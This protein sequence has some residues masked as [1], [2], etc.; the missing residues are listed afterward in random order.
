MLRG[1]RWQFLA[2]ILATIL[3]VISLLSRT[4]SDSAGDVIPS[5]EPTIQTPPSPVV[6]S[7]PTPLISQPQPTQ[8]S[9]LFGDGI[10]TYRE[11][12]V[13]NV[14]RLNPL[15]AGLNPVDQDITA[16]IFEGLIRINQ[17][18]E[19]EPALAREWVISFDGL[20]YVFILR[21]DILWQ[22][23]VP[24]TADDV[25]FTMSLLSAPDFPGPESLRAFWRTVEVEKLGEHMVRFR[26]AQRLGS[27]LDALRIGILPYH[28]L[29]GTPASALTGHRFNL[30]PVG[31]GPY[32][33]EAIRAEGDRIRAVDLRVSPVY[34]VRPGVESPL[35]LERIS[36]RLFDT[37]NQVTQALE[38]GEVDGYAARSRV[39][40]LPLLAVRGDFASH[41]TI[42]PALGVIIFNWTNDDLPYFRDMRVR[43]ALQTGL[44]RTSIIERHLLN[45]AV[46]ADSPLLQNS[47]AYA[48]GLPW[49]A[50]SIDVARSLLDRANVRLVVPEGEDASQRPA[51]RFSFTILTVS[52]PALVNV[53]QE[54]ATQWDQ[55]NINAEVE[56]VDQT[57]FFERLQSGDFGAA[58]VELSMSG[59]ADPD[60]YA[61]WHQGQYPDGLNYGGANDRPTSEQLE[62]ARADADGT[63]RIQ[64]YRLFQ[65]EFIERAVAIPLYYPL[66]TYVVTDRLEGLQLGFIASPPDRFLTIQDWRIAAP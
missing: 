53:A 34:R 46:R 51:V 29:Q 33:L 38:A 15:L 31:T 39:E 35:A 52:D 48:S 62:R 58:L 17:Y 26:L 7:S 22:D 8:S 66:Y 54:I 37:F 16:L 3:F 19:P 1:F 49:P 12:L 61:F 44:E 14:Q 57:L 42:E 9:F 13:G 30:T 20:E 11:A 6:P 27:F 60:V 25:V 18:G 45:L 2:L 10:P 24:F 56:A 47:W 32:Q 50:Y 21:D 55:L 4:S 41:T 43:Q 28:A 63:N 59:S 23:G 36:F 65:Q 64:H 40:R 5:I